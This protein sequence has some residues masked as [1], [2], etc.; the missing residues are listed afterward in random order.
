MPDRQTYLGRQAVLGQICILCC[1]SCILKYSFKPFSI[2][3]ED[4]G[5]YFIQYFVE[6]IACYSGDRYRIAK[7]V[8][9][10]ALDMIKDMP[11]KTKDR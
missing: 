10:T 3:H 7:E 6:D 11:V 5:F 8:A 1:Y 4:H 9:E 2:C